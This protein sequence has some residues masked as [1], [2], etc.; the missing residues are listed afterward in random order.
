MCRNP[1]SDL[2]EIILGRHT[3]R[4]KLEIKS[5]HRILRNG[6]FNKVSTPGSETEES[7]EEQE[8]EILTREKGGERYIPW[9]T[10]SIARYR[11]IHTLGYS[12]HSQVQRDT[13]PGVLRP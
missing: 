2:Y 12:V 11:E 3:N 8:E 6:P 10:P 9:G 7:D 5:R 4:L 13:H 1:C